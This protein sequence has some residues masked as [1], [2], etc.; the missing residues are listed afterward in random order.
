[1]AMLNNQMVMSKLAIGQSSDDRPHHLQMQP[2]SELWHKRPMDYPVAHAR[3]Q[4]K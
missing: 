3:R 1:M 4:N 2:F